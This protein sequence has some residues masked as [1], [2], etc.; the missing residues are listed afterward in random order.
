MVEGIVDVVNII[1]RSLSG[2]TSEDSERISR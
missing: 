2:E 1:P